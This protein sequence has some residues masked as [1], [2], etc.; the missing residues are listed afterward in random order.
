MRR[1]GLHQRQKLVAQ[2]DEGL[3]LAAPAQGEA[4]NLAVK[5]ERLV[6]VADFQRD[7][8]DADEAGQIGGHMSFPFSRRPRALEWVFGKPLWR[9]G[10][11]VAVLVGS[12]AIG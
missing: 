5:R 1:V 4:E 9:T 7:V 2:I 12:F 11:V 3:A 6:D 8:I 10:D